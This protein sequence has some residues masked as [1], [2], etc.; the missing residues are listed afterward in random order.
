MAKFKNVLLED[1]V[2]VASN[3][4]EDGQAAHVIFKNLEI[5]LGGFKKGPLVATRVASITIPINE[6]DTDILVQ[7]DIRGSVSIDQGARA[8]LVTH[9][10]GKTNLVNLPEHTCEYEDF[11][12]SFDSTLPAGVDYQATFDS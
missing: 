2:Q 1:V 10:G 5:S 11:L 3:I 4:S 7:Q 9:L 6:N 8:V 12:Y